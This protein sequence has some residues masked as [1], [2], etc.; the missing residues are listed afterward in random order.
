MALGQKCTYY[1]HGRAARNRRNQSTFGPK[2]GRAFGLICILF[3]LILTS[4]GT[5]KKVRINTSKTSTS[6]AIT[7]QTQSPFEAP[8]PSAPTTKITNKDRALAYIE[9][10]A[11]IAQQEMRI[12]KIPASITLAQGLLESA[13][14][15]GRLAQEA[16]NHF[17][18]KCH[19]EWTGK[20]IFHD[21]DAKGE[22]FRVYEDAKESY[23]DHSLFL[24]TRSR[25]DFLFDIK[26]TN[27]KA[28]AKGLKKAGYATDPKY[29]DKLIDLI[30]RYDLHRFDSDRK[31]KTKDL[32]EN[33]PVEEKKSP[34]AP[35]VHRVEKGDTLYSISK[36][37]KVSVDLL[38]EHNKLKAQTIFPG[39][40]LSIPKIY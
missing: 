3:G 23:R 32:V 1:P 33:E 34:I 40:E 37:Y 18:I 27:Y 2:R 30:E 10:F 39:Q 15:Q 14:G 35:A 9:T 25:Y 12:Y 29:P 11:P 5:A 6:Q 19:K 26:S 17:G 28:W 4:C 16:N 7:K 31:I 21:D 13:I 38:I 22:C 24:K 36:K 8:K 20:Q